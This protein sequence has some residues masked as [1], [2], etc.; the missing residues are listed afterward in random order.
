MNLNKYTE[1]AQEAILA[2]QQ[3]AERGPHAELLPEHVA[4][5]LVDQT[6]G[7]VP[8]VLGKMSVDPSK[9][10]AALRAR[11]EAL[12]KVHGGQTG[13]SSRARA[14]FSAAEEETARLKDDF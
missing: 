11:I 7:I 8:A 3:L 1:K 5:A 13:L 2:A 14:I 9:A 6:D 10:S 12:P 4:L